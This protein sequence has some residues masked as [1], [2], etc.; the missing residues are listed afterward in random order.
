MKIQPLKVDWRGGGGKNIFPATDFCEQIK[1]GFSL[2][3]ICGF[4]HS[5]AVFGGCLH[6]TWVSSWCSG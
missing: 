2:M 5:D 1:M 6:P 3:R 4:P